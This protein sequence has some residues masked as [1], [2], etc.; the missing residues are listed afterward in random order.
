[1][2]HVGIVGPAREAREHDEDRGGG[3]EG[4]A[5]ALAL[6]SPLDQ[7]V[8]GDRA[9]VRGPQEL[10]LV[11]H[12]RRHPRLGREDGLRVAPLAQRGRR[13][14]GG[15]Q[16]GAP[17]RGDAGEHGLEAG[18]P[19]GGVARGG[20]VVARLALFGEMDLWEVADSRS[21]EQAQEQ[22]SSDRC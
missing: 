9:S 20:V 10:P 16:Q 1:M 21:G 11:V 19:A 15:G 14:G 4:R 12:A 13:E 22:K 5:L 2:L 6:A 7:R 8:E 17:E 3:R 18:R